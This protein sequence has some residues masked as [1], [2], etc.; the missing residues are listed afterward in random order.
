VITH[1]PAVGGQGSRVGQEIPDPSEQSARSTHLTVGRSI[2]M[3]GGIRNRKPRVLIVE[4]ESIVGMHL[5]A[6]VEDMGCEA[7]GPAS[8]AITAL[9]IVLHDQLDAAVLDILLIDRSVGPVA[10]ALARKGVPFAF[11]TAYSPDSLPAAHR[12]RPYVHKPFLDGEIR[13]VLETLLAQT[14]LSSSVP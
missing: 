6:I 1:A 4:D 9:P 8:L 10:D 11:V 13:S 12:E 2:L 5:T 3:Q 14:A 7:V